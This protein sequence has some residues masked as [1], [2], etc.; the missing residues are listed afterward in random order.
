LKNHLL[1][2]IARTPLMGLTARAVCRNTWLM[3]GG[4]LGFFSR[5]GKRYWNQDT[6]PGQTMASAERRQD[7]PGSQ[8][9]GDLAAYLKTL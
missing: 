2:L 6:R 4:Y 3:E 8:T 9:A 7:D 1:T 5:D